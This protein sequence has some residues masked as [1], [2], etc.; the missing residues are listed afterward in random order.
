MTRKLADR[1]GY[2]D[3]RELLALDADEMLLMIAGVE[4][5][6]AQR[7]NYLTDPCFK[8]QSDPNPF[9]NPDIDLETTALRPQRRFS[10]GLGTGDGDLTKEGEGRDSPGSEIDNR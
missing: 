7:P 4:P 6:I 3:S 5:V 10:R 2:P 1:I 8:G 9:H